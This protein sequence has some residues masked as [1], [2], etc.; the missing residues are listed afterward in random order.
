MNKP[1]DLSK[2]IEDY[3]L[4]TVP[5][6]QRK[7]GWELMWMTTGLVTTLVQLLIGSYVTARAGVAYGVLAGI[8]VG[9]FGGTLGWLVGRLALEEGLSSTVLSRFYGLGARSSFVAS[10]IYSFMILGFLG[11][12]NA[13]LY[14]GTIFAF[15]LQDTLWT[16]I[17]IY[18]LLTVL[19]IYLTIYG[20]RQVLRVSSTLTISFLVLLVYVV[21]RAAVATGEPWNHILAHSALLPGL[22]NIR[23]RFYSALVALAGSAG[24]LALSDADY[25]RYARTSR[26]VAGM[27]YAGA[28]A[29]DVLMVIAGTT[30]IYGGSRDVVSYITRQGMAAG[31]EALSRANEMA[32]NNTGA[33]FIIFA[34]VAGF[35]LMYV[36]QA[37]AQV[38]NTYSGSLALSNLFDAV[39]QWR[40]GRLVM[41]ILGNLI[42]LAMTAMGILQLLQAWLGVLGILT[43]TFVGVILADFYLVRRGTRARRDQVEY[44]NSAGLATVLVA[45]CGA[46]WLQEKAAGIF[47][48]GFLIALLLSLV[49]Y[50]L[51]RLTILKPGTLSGGPAPPSLALAEAPENNA[52]AAKE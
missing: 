32:Q 8:L 7:S 38:L 34:G 23:D 43:T 29:I 13:L 27:A 42:G 50:P 30:I 35:L 26:D 39:L 11:L 2:V 6:R 45:A 22:G 47:R 15:R 18:G 3:A 49:L 37:K 52:A 40:P 51:L 21:W 14:N 24:A 19:W 48:L 10:G 16:R 44:Y 46:Y 5:E 41:V 1:K 31:S 33:Y 9:L 4:E 36:A 20:V 28:F 25:A 17:I 12:E